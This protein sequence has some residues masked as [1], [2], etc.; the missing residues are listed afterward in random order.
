MSVPQEVRKEIEQLR[1]EIRQHDH[2]YYVDSAPIISDLE[3]ERL[4]E[5]LK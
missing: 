4:L 1:D 2:R 3:Y 5:K